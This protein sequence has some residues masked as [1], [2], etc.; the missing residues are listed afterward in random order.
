MRRRLHDLPLARSISHSS[1]AANRPEP[2]GPELP[3]WSCERQFA[4]E[5][6]WKVR[7]LGGRRMGG[8]SR[9]PT[10]AANAWATGFAFA[11]MPGPSSGRERTVV[12]GEG[13]RSNKTDPSSP[14]A[15]GLP[16]SRHGPETCWSWMR[17]MTVALYH[18]A[19][20]IECVLPASGPSRF[21]T[22]VRKAGSVSRR[23]IRLSPVILAAGHIQET[24]LF[25]RSFMVWGVS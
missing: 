22:S 25:H 5:E 23:L 14:P 13:N 1:P 19:W 18:A 11:W 4:V 12:S 8:D 2:N 7:P 20:R 15:S 21:G 6:Q 24:I 16:E 3:K 17:D 10:D 9:D